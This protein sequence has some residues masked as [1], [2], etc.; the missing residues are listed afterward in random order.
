MLKH[1][2]AMHG[3]YILLGRLSLRG[4]ASSAHTKLI[5]RHWRKEKM[6][7]LSEVVTQEVLDR[8]VNLSKDRLVTQAR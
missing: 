7:G 2:F 8:A 4:R 6:D 5:I 1:L 3:T